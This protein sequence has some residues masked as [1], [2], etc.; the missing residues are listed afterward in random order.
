MNQIVVF[1]KA[2]ELGQVK[3]RMNPSLSPRDSV[4]L[5]KA[6]T[7]AVLT[8]LHK[9]SFENA[10]IKISLA[11]APDSKHAFFQELTRKFAC[12]LLE[13]GEGD[14][15]E[16]MVRVAKRIFQKNYIFNGF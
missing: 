2:P 16:R 13:Q 3:T 10:D 12:L 6:L 8:T 7:H 15:G 1:A 5:M 4:L 11:C 9:M 14:L